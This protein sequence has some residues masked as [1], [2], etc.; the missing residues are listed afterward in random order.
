MDGSGDADVSVEAR[1]RRD[2][3]VVYDDTTVNFFIFS[4]TEVVNYKIS[5]IR[6]GCLSF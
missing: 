2:R 5:I 6:Y 4:V 3:L 1:S